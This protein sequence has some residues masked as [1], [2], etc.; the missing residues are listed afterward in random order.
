LTEKIKFDKK[1]KKVHLICSWNISWWRLHGL[2]KRL[3]MAIFSEK[4]DMF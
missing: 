3:D 4:K 2:S 1:D